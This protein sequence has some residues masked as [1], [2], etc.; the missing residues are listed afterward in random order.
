MLLVS[1][2]QLQFTADQVV[3]VD[4]ATMR[5]GSVTK[6]VSQNHAAG[7]VHGQPTGLDHTQPGGKLQLFSWADTNRS[8]KGAVYAIRLVME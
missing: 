1:A 8:G 5:T 4:L 3:L 6:V 7:G 2:L